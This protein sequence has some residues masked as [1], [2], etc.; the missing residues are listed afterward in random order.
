[1]I[2][3]I[4]KFLCVYIALILISERIIL[5]FQKKSECY[6]EDDEALDRIGCFF[7]RCFWPALIMWLFVVLA[8]ICIDFEITFKL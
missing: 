3:F 8:K 4:Y 5:H 6:I 1:M 2:R 7:R